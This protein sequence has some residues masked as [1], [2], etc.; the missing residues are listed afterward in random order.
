MVSF[1]NSEESCFYQKE[2]WKR[3]VLPQ[4]SAIESMLV[5]GTETITKS[6]LLSRLS[7]LSVSL[8]PI[9]FLNNP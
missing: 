5:N 1:I 7:A 8:T 2:I 9:S 3:S 6:V 4:Y